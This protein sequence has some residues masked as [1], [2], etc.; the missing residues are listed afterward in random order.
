MTFDSRLRRETVQQNRLGP[1]QNKPEQAEPATRLRNSRSPDRDG[2]WRYRGQGRRGR[3]GELAEDRD[4][5]R[6]V[7]REL[8]AARLMIDRAATL[9]NREARELRRAALGR[10]SMCSRWLDEL[11]AKR[12]P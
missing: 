10:V 1:A 5:L 4:D 12:S 11:I 8:D 2:R 3:R 7:T 6:H 9:P